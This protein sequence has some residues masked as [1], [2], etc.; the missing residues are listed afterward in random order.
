MR[1]ASWNLGAG[2]AARSVLKG[3]QEPVFPLDILGKLIYYDRRKHEQ[4]FASIEN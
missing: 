4:R 1:D 2:A 3:R